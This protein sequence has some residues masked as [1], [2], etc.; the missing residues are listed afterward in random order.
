M[1][2]RVIL[3][4]LERF[5][6]ALIEHFAGSLPLWLA[7]VQCIIIPVS[8]KVTE[9]A[10]NTQRTLFN[11][12]I[13]VDIDRRNERLQKKIR[14]AEVERVPYMIIIGEKEESIGMISVRSKAQGD[15]GRMKL[16]EFMERIKEEIGK[17]VR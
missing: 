11:A 5:M 12:N 4:S 13:R 16:G 15:I 14:D 9:Y 3:G 10:E 2:H 6:G 7:P 1:L 17:K 8:D